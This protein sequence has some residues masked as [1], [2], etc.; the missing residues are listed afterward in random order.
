MTKDRA[1]N[2]AAKRKIWVM[3]TAEMFEGGIQQSKEARS[4]EVF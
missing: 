3:M 4:G 2:S 1:E